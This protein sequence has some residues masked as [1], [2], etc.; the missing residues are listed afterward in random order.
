MT[1]TKQDGVPPGNMNSL[2]ILSD[3]TISGV[4]SNGLSLEIAKIAMAQFNNENGLNQQ[5]NGLYTESVESGSLL[6]GTPG[7]NGGGLLVGGSLEL[8]N[9]DLASE[10]TKIIT[11]Q[12]G[13]Q[14]NARMI[15]LTDQV[16]QE[17]L[18]LRQ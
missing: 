13:Y 16:L 11:F 15:T 17:T 6:L 2:E 18:N 8:S 4:F 5:G 12:R 9:V 1:F 14:A 10:F 3:G 7:A